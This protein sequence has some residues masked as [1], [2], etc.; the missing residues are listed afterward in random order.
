[1]DHA[2]LKTILDSH[3]AFLNNPTTGRRADLRWAD[4]READL[5]GADLTGADLEGA[6]RLPWDAPIPG[7]AVVNRR[8]HPESVPVKSAP[9]E[10]APAA[11]DL[12]ARFDA[13]ASELGV[14]IV[15]LQV[16]TTV[17]L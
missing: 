8:L 1:M 5:T 16:K 10:T 6:Y 12:R 9:K 4:L 17:D 14:E 13:L 7:W 3:A 2:K 11:S 15:S